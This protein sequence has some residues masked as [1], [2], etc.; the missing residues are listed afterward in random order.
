MV[1]VQEISRNRVFHIKNMISDLE[2]Q[3]L[4][5]LIDKKPYEAKKHYH[6]IHFANY[7]MKFILEKIRELNNSKI[8]DILNKMES[9]EIV[10]GKK[11][12]CKTIV[13]GYPKYT[14]NMESHYDGWSDWNFLIAFGNSSSLITGRDKIDVENGDVVIFDGGRVRHMVKIYKKG[15]NL[16]HKKYRRISIQYRRNMSKTLP[17]DIKN[18]KYFSRYG[19]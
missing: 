5:A 1:T 19:H 12:K 2:Q 7:N 3:K 10:N 18:Y 17:A 6:S 9:K 15:T 16:K 14:T 13:V 8:N 4:I 11:N